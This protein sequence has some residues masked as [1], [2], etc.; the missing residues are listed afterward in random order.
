MSLNA[1]ERLDFKPEIDL[2]APRLNHQC[3]TYVSYR[4]DPEALAIDAYSL[5][6]SNLNLYAFPPFSVIPTVLNKLKSTGHC[7]AAGLAN[8]S[9]VSGS[10]QATQTK[11]SISESPERPSS[12]AKSSQGNS[13]NLAQTEPTNLS[14][15]REGLPK[16]DLSL[17]ATDVLMAHGERVFLSSIKLILSDGKS[18]VQEETLKI[19]SF[20]TWCNKWY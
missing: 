16:Y 15:I 14:L 17:R 8:T 7:C 9:M 11:T 19:I 13:T 12:A 2:F 4:P 20:L 1:L 10:P 5:D 3:S 6:W 18:T